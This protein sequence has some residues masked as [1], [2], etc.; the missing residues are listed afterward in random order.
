VGEVRE[1]PIL[2]WHGVP[3]ARLV[4]EASGLPAVVENDVNTLAIAEQWF[5]AGRDVDWFCVVTVGA[6]VGCGLV[7]DGQLAHGAMGAAGELGHCTIEPDGAPC[8]CGKRGCLETVASDGAI[9]A[10]IRAAGCD[11]GADIAAAAARA[12]DGD[13]RCRAAFARAGEALGQGIAMLANLVNPSLIVLSGEGVVASDLLLQALRESL[14]RHAFPS[15]RGCDVLARPL[16]DEIWARGAAS[17]VV[18]RLVSRPSRRPAR[19]PQGS[20]AA[21]S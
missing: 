12:R 5:G 6:G 4:A 11:P 1:S 16:G 2:G 19:S 14:D 3:L 21:R 8:S 20:G 7:L 17:T 15:A 9:L 10:A 13:E 18:E